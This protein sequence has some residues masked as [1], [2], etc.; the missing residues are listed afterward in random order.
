[1]ASGAVAAAYQYL[2]GYKGLAF[3]TRSAD[4]LQLP[5]SAQVVAAKSIWIPG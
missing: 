1:M 3:Y 5:P 2:V 4:P